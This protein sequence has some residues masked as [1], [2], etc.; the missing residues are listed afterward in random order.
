MRDTR[1]DKL[2]EISTA[3]VK[4]AQLARLENEEARTLKELHRKALERGS[5]QEQAPAVSS[6]SNAS[7]W[8]K[9]M[10]F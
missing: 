10:N 1:A 5:A 9:S 2:K 6:L 7:R 8:Q 3:N 4:A